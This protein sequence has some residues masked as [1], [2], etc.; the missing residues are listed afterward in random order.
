MT[1]IPDPNIDYDGILKENDA[2]R[3][4]YEAAERLHEEDEI[5]FWFMEF[6]LYSVMIIGLGAIFIK[7][8]IK[9]I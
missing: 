6:I 1:L 9:F 3:R 5:P 8:I 4:G 2:Y 7:L